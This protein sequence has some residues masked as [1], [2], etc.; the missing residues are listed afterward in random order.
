M[1]I[2]DFIKST[3]ES[4]QD[5]LSGEI[6]TYIESLA[7]VN[8]NL[9]GV[10]ICDINGKLVAEGDSEYPFSFQSCSKPISYCIARNKLSKDE[11]HRHVGFEP[12]GAKFNAHILNKDSL[13]HNP[14]INAGAIVISHLIK[15]R[16]KLSTCIDSV[17]D[18]YKRMTGRINSYGSI[19]V[20]IGVYLSESEKSDRNKSLAYFMKEA[21]KAFQRDIDDSE[22]KEILD[23]YYMNCSITVNAKLAS[24]LASTLANGGVCP[25]TKETIFSKEVVRDCCKLMQTCGMYD[26]SGTFFF[27]VGLPAKSGVSGCVIMVVP[28]KMGV[29]V[30]SP[31]TDDFGNSIRGVK[32]CQA[33]K[34]S[35]LIETYSKLEK[36]LP[37]DMLKYRLLHLISSGDLDKI[38]EFYAEN[39]KKGTPINLSQGDYDDRTPLHIAVTNKHW[40]IASFL[41]DQK[42]DIKI[43]DVYGKTPIDCC[44]DDAPIDIVKRLEF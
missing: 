11:V 6:E 27:E 12:S 41:L 44:E 1:S 14:M 15:D 30:F 7:K 18:I 8:P 9:F 19:H 42:V 33:L 25:I 24:I 3:Y 4:L 26:S 38:K 22:L 28:G 36:E 10:S 23:F 37:E 20:D 43:K 5:D 17:L 2:E 13:P 39:N 34:K 31:R 35:G 40:N 16:E 21:G 32:F 29:C